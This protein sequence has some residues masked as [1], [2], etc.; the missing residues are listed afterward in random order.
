MKIRSSKAGVSVPGDV[1]IRR[2]HPWLA[3]VPDAAHFY[4]VHSYAPDAAS[5][6]TIATTTHGADF[7]SIVGEGGVLGVQFHPEKSSLMGTRLLQ[8]IVRA[9]G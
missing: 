4:F 7:A 2:A 6:A 5:A 9:I 8:S 3:A 1:R